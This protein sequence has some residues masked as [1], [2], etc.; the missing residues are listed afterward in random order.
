ML[1]GSIGL[2]VMSCWFSVFG[3]RVSVLLSLRSRNMAVGSVYVGG[4][5]TLDYLLFLYSF[6]KRTR[7]FTLV[8]VR[9]VLG[10]VPT[11]RVAGRRL[12]RISG[13]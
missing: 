9:C 4:V 3:F 12:D 10:G 13:G 8:S 11:C 6:T 5:V 2:L 1:N 7:G